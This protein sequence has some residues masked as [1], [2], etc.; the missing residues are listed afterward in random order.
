MQT[1]PADLPA[2]VF[3]VQHVPP[4]FSSTLPH[5]LSSVSA[6]PARHPQNEETIEPGVIYVAPPDHHLLLEG[7]KMLVTRGPKENRFRPSIDALFRSAAYTYGSRVIGV[8]LTGYLDDGASGLWSVQRQGGLAVVQ[9]PQDAQ[10]PAMPTN[11]LKLVA[12]DYV[13]PLAEL[14]ALLVRLSAESA[15]PKPRLPAAE[16]DLLA[17][18]LTI[19]KQDDA[20]ELR[21][22]A[23]GRPTPFICPECHAALTLLVEG[24]LIRYRCRAG[25]AYTFS[26]LLA[27][28]TES[29]KKLL[30][31]GV[32][33]LEETQTLLHNV[34]G[35]FSENNQ[36][37]VADLLFQ[38]AKQAAKQAQV[39]HN[40][41]RQY[42]ALSES[43]PFHGKKQP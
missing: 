12:A 43:L 35:H 30:Y 17:I 28:V 8:V 23:Q 42:E 21:L 41:I 5:L 4:G 14:G 26:A 3:V 7:H 10:S 18:E 32:Q 2:S 34:G 13:V 19:A 16:L 38:Q 36:S 20:L 37:E 1:L 33:G 31:Q 15:P 9:D 27:E 22:L 24:Q 40:A 25:H 11:A 6:L 39:V 29:V